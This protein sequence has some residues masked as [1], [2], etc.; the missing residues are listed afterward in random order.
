MF[1][2]RVNDLQI[3]YTCSRHFA[4]IEEVNEAASVWVNKFTSCFTVMRRKF[5]SW[6]A[7]AMSTVR[8]S[9]KIPKWAKFRAVIVFSSWT[10]LWS[11][12]C[13]TSAQNCPMRSQS[14]LLLH[15]APTFLCTTRH[16]LIEIPRERWRSLARQICNRPRS[17]WYFMCS[18]GYVL[19]NASL[20]L[21]ISAYWPS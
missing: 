14:R 21:H 5:S 20:F 10:V 1:K 4:L 7:L 17:L 12:L 8:A 13:L 6:S 3:F 19:K 16:M 11:C 18:Q 9:S 2:K 15:S